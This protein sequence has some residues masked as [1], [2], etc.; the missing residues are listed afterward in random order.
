MSSLARRPAGV[1]LIAVLA[2]IEGAFAIVAG[3]LLLILKDDAEVR[4]ASGGEPALVTSAIL[5]ILFG[6]VVVLIAG[7]LLRGSRGARIVVT[8]LQLLAIASDALTAWADPARFAWSAVG[9][10][11]SLIIVILLWTGRAND[12]FRTR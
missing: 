5:T 9:A 2:W 11:I 8:V 12:F 3:V 6:V 4:D 1:T 7:G 10:L